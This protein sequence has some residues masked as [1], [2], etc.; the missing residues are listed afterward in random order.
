MPIELAWSGR[1]EFDL[2][3]DYDR[4]AV[5]KIVLDEGTAKNLRELVN[6]RLLVMIWP[7]ILPARPVRALWERIFP[8]LRAAA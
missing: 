6:G 4:A 3:D 7:Q 2:D 8:Q 5:Y 1:R